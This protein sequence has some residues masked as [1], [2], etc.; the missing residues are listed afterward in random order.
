MLQFTN[1]V[2]HRD[3]HLEKK[4]FQFGEA[5]YNCMVNFLLLLFRPRSRTISTSDANRYGLRI[6][7]QK[8]RMTTN[9]HS[10]SVPSTKTT[11]SIGK[12]NKDKYSKSLTPSKIIIS[13]SNRRNGLS[14]S[15]FITVVIHVVL[16]PNKHNLYVIRCGIQ[17]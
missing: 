14:L 3:C 17:H 4:H 6:K 9:D 1:C 11:G 10:L 15:P 16:Q 5:Y 12:R 7:M 2:D 8:Q 13:D